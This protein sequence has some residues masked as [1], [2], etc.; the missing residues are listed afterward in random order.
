[1]LKERGFGILQVVFLAAALMVAAVAVTSYFSRQSRLSSMRRQNSKYQQLVDHL[2]AQLNDAAICSRALSGITIRTDL[3]R[4]GAVSLDIGYGD[5]P[6]PIKA[7]WKA[8]EAA[9]DIRGVE[10]KTIRQAQVRDAS[11][12]I[13]PRTVVYDYPRVMTTTANQFNKFYG[14]MRISPNDAHWNIENEEG[15]VKLALIVN[16][17]G[18]VH[19]CFGEFSSAE[20]CESNGGSYDASSNSNPDERCN[21]DIFC[22]NHSVGLVADQSACVYPYLP[23]SMGY[24][25]G[26]YKYLCTWCNR[27][28]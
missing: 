13:Q 26:T 4:W 2:Q 17:A 21:P 19:Q 5:S 18:V 10:I 27:N 25:D 20:A 12:T 23:N 8:K 1:M 9:Y 7:G 16:A 14:R 22:F 28:R 15:W 6:G 11:G 3:D 24:I